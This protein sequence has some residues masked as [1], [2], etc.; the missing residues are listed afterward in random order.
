[1]TLKPHLSDPGQSS[2]ICPSGCFLA[3][4]SSLIS[5]FPKNIFVHI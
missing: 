4:L 1:M 2:V 5:D 3:G